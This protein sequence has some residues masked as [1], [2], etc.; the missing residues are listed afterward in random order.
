MKKLTRKNAIIIGA[1]SLVLVAAILCIILIPNC[2]G[3][4]P[5]ENTEDKPIIIVETTDKPF[6]S[7]GTTQYVVVRPS[8][9]TNY[10]EYA[11]E[12]LVKY[13]AEATGVTLPV[14]SD[15]SYTFDENATVISVGNTT[16]FEGSGITLDK[17]LL[18]DEG[19][20]IETKGK[21]IIM[22]G[23]AGYGTLFSVYEFLA[24]TVGFEAYAPDEIVVNNTN[25]IPLYNF[26]ITDYPSVRNA[27]G[28]WYVASSD[29]RFAAKWRVLA[30]TGTSIFDGSIWGT[31]AHAIYSYIEPAIYHE[32]HPE[33]FAHSIDKNGNI[34]PTL[35]GAGEP[36]Q[37]CFSS[38]EGGAA[39]I[40]V[41]SMKQKVFYD[42][43]KRHRWI[44]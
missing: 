24:H 6:L 2:N 3:N 20:R 41:E 32:S 39:D 33:Y 25:N 7:A 15:S 17:N 9:P 11:V 31:W 23:C 37:I 42:R 26:S 10:E 44:L 12:E 8:E 5:D 30:G 29:A 14:K 34:V 16:I 21:A 4:P 19:Y 28:G 36:T 1:I 35:T 43:S 13:F 18:G 40:V 38:I 22:N 27:A